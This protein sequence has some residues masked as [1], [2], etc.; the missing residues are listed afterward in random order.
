MSLKK[1]VYSMLVVSAA[2]TFNTTL[3]SLLS[4]S[5]YEP[6]RTVS[7]INAARRL[8]AERAFDF[9]LINSPLPDDNGISFAIDCC[10]SKGT[11]VLLMVRNEIHDEIY[12]KVVSHGVFTLPKPTSKSTMSRALMWMISARERFHHF[13]TKNQSIEQKMEEIRLVNRAKWLLISNQNM[14]E[15]DAHRFIEKQAMNLCISKR[16]M[17]EK[18]IREYT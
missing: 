3:H 13:E 7:S 16:S 14:T 17:A 6:I 11:V 8:L 9:I 4:E 1:R 15:P 5:T 10:T 18:I 12:D 2:E